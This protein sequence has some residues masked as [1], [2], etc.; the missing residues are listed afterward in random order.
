MDSLTL[1]I[2]LKPF[3]QASLPS[4]YGHLGTRSS[5]VPAFG[6][7]IGPAGHDEL[8][9]GDRGTVTSMVLAPCSGAP[10]MMA[11]TASYL[12]WRALSVP[13][14]TVRPEFRA[15]STV[16]SALPMTWVT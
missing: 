5:N 9:V 7:E 8:T 15:R 13:K 3:Q 14:S 2:R 4:Q 11:A 1:D 6:P 16:P 12:A 10:A